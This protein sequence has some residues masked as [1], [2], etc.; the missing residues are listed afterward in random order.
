MDMRTEGTSG[1]RA[2]GHPHAPLQKLRLADGRELAWYEYGD[3]DGVPCLYVTGT[4]ASGV[5]G[6]LFDDRA[7]RAGVRWISVDK[8]GYGHSSYHEA[9]RLADWPRDVAA[10]ADHLGLGRFAGVGESGGGPHVLAMAHGLGP[11][12]TVAVSLAG[13]GPGHEAW[14]RKGMKPLNRQL[15]WLAQH[16]PWL[17][18]WPLGAMARALENPQ[19]QQRW[20]DK[21]LKVAPPCDRAVM[22]RNPQMLPQTMQAF[23][24]AF[25]EGPRGAAQELAIFGRPWGFALGD[26]RAPVE[27][28]H[29]S[30]DV[31]VPVE[32]ARRVAE[33]IPGCTLRVFEGQGHVLFEHADE[34]MARIR[35]AA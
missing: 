33:Q 18:R 27:V 16:A 35:R 25:R 11:R 29:G 12:L 3:P 23:R 8:P 19:T 28:W 6:S 31:N 22:E 4:P 5:I 30:E 26:I 13:M 2:P 1:L 9:R 32:I 21:Q 17:L 7:R 34:L 15:F 20:L 14:V 24:L 10:L